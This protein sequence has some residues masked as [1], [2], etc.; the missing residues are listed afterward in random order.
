MSAV[1]EILNFKKTDD[2]DFYKLLG[3]DENST[4]SFEIMRSVL[5]NVLLFFPW[6]VVEINL[7]IDKRLICLQNTFY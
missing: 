1:D 3:C 5:S 2:D 7:T 4:V 6:S